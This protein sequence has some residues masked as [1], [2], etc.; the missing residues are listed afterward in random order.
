MK[1]SLQLKMG[2]HLTMT[3]QLQQAIRLLQ[4]SSLELQQEIQQA[5]DSNPLLEIEDE[6]SEAKDPVKENRD[7]ADTDFSDNSIVNIEK[8]TSTVDTAESM[9]KETMDDLAMDTTWDEVY[10]ASPMSGSGS[11]SM[12]DDDMP[13]QGETTEGLYEH[14]EWQKNLTPFSETDLAIAT[15]IIDAVD[16]RGYLTQSTDDILE[17]M[18]DEN[19]ELDE[20]EAVL[21][22]I[23]H[24]DPVG[25]AARD[26]S[27]CLLIQLA[28]FSNTT[29]HI[30]N[31]RLLIKDY[32]TLIA[33][34][35]F[36]LLMRKTK[37]KENELRDA[38]TLIQS[39]NPR[40]GL[41]ITA[42]DD[43][44]VIPD[45]TVLKKNGRWV[46][47]LNPDNMPKIGVNQQYAAMARSSKNQSDSQFIRGH[48]QEAKW[49]IK[50]IESRNDTLL[51]V[52]N[53]IVQF[54]QGFF[55]YGEE[56]MK[57]MV[58]NDIAEAVEM[59]ESTISRVTTQKYMHT[60]R[61]LFELK[62]F[63]SSHV[64]TDD[65]GECSSTAIRA[66]IKKLVAAEN[67]KKPL[68][69]SKMAQLLAEQG[70]NV[71]RRTI[72]KYREAMLIP[73]SNQRK[74]L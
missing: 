10:T 13:F 17:A 36:R 72:A 28:Q 63:F 60:P 1:A 66:F 62:Y 18:G 30:D 41:L 71:A 55:E 69:D 40:P 52:A 51:K 31:A 61:G 70:I 22:R 44:F 7:Q 21:K 2:Q 32:L 74:S 37:L 46:V 23:Q 25:V 45:V 16:E 19:V 43:E 33:G 29:P 39:L 38:I 64:S 3:P 57:P 42:T 34:R 12:R 53:C 9:T 58:L 4:L 65:G 11:A 5:L 47:E 20:V 27:E 49:F 54:Q 24:F 8:D 56:A 6:F 26:L 67:Q 59:H 73:P 14:L 35:D 50:S 15:A 68:S 48:L